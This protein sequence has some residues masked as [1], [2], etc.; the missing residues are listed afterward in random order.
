MAKV[1]LSAEE[2]TDIY[3]FGLT[4]LQTPQ[5]LSRINVFPN[6]FR[7]SVSLSNLS[8][9][10]SGSDP[11]E[12]SVYDSNGRRSF[13]TILTDKVNSTQLDLAN[14]PSGMYWLHIRNGQG[15]VTYRMVKR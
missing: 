1:E 13:D 10:F 2:I 4:S 3:D 12:F 6:P 11:L 9:A 8:D 7:Q 14:L 5:E 15:M